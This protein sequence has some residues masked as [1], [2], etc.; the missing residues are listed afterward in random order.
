MACRLAGDKPLPEAMLTK[1]HDAI[2]YLL[3]SRPRLMTL[4]V[5]SEGI[6]V[7]KLIDALG[8]GAKGECTKQF[9]S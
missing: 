4:M 9:H 3:A 2:E 7:L 8:F 6:T 1:F 5:A